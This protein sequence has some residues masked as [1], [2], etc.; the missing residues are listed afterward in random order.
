MK[1]NS[2]WKYV[3]QPNIDIEMPVGAQ[4][5]SVR[6]QGNDICMWTLVSPDAPKEK[7]I[8]MVF[9]TGHDVPPVQMKFLGTA[10]LQSGG[11]VFHVFE[12]EQSSLVDISE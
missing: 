12:L 6:E 4:I 7:R 3:L 1:S 9:G 10:H 8:F 2:I 5:L 11:L